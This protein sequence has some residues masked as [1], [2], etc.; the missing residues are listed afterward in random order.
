MITAERLKYLLD[1]DPITGVFT[2]KVNAGA[3]HAGDVAGHLTVRGYVTI[4]IDGKNYACHR[5]AFL[6]MT[7]GFPAEVDHRDLDKTNNRWANLRA[8]SRSTNVMNTRLDSKTRSG[9]KGVYWDSQNRCWRAN[10]SVN[11]KQR[12]LGLFKEFADAVEFRQLAAEM[13]YGDF[14]RHV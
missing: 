3:A 5:L 14:C 4:G 6:W 11:G 13:I 9:A 12:H 2:R 10:V 1:Y 7:G 8:A